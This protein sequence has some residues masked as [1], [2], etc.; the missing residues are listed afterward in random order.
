L[1]KSVLYRGTTSQ[2][3]EILDSLKGPGFSR[4]ANAAKSI[5][6]QPLRDVFSCTTGFFRKLFSGAEKGEKPKSFSPEPFDP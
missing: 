6:L 5:R 4:A 2:P 1:H 3:A